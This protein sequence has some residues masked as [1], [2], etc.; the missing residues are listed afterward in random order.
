MIL[1]LWHF[2]EKNQ[3][4]VLIRLPVNLLFSAKQNC[5]VMPFGVGNQ[6]ILPQNNLS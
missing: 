1:I 4:K 5:V 2:Q 6:N 3:P